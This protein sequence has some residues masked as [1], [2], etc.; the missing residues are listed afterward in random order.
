[1]R[2]RSIAEITVRAVALWMFINALAGIAPLFHSWGEYPEVK[3][4]KALAAFVA[5]VLPML[6]SWAVWAKAAWDRV[7]AGS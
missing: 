6:V 2:A 1:V 4:T 7:P 3:E 5:A